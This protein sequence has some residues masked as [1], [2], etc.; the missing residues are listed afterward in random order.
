MMAKKA[1]KWSNLTGQLP[2]PPVE[3]D[4][5]ELAV[6]ADMDLYRGKPMRELAQEFQGVCEES[7]FAALEEKKRSVKNAAL[8]RLIRDELKKV[9]ELSGQDMWRGEGWT[10]SP[11]NTVI[12]IVSDRAAFL[13]WIRSTGRES[14]LDVSPPRIKSIVVDALNEDE[15]VTLTPSERAVLAAGEPGSCAPPPGITVFLLPGIN[16]RPTT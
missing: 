12:P 5:R 2:E 6:R 14:F 7:D 1:R 10:F 8:E 11:K 16:H 9:E 15:A 13:A 3:L 4:A